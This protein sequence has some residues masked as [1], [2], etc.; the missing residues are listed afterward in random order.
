MEFISSV[1]ET[2]S[3]STMRG[4]VLQTLTT[5]TESQKFYTNSIFQRL[6]TVEYFVHI[7]LTNTAY[8]HISDSLNQ[9]HTQ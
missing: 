2:A 3:V 4:D 7:L 1:S 9:I 5:E 8:V 6:I